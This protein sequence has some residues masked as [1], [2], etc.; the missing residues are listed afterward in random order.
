MSNLIV[1]QSPKHGQND[2]YLKR[3]GSTLNELWRQK[4]VEQALFQYS[5]VLTWILTQKWAAMAVFQALFC[6]VIVRPFVNKELG[7]SKM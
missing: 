6:F 5:Q 2:W 1:F 3:Q 7:N 4:G